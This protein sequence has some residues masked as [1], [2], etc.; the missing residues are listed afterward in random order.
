MTWD[1]TNL[2][3][4]SRNPVPDY[5]SITMEISRDR[6]TAANMVTCDNRNPSLDDCPVGK[7]DGSTYLARTLNEPCIKMVSI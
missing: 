4:H 6:T 7:I 2:T 5:Y 1:L 3:L